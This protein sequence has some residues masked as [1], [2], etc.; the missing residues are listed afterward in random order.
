LG[1]YDIQQVLTIPEPEDL[2][3]NNSPVKRVWEWIHKCLAG[4]EL[5]GQP[6]TLLFKKIFKKF[7]F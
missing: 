2:Q 1:E 3:M 5:K 6:G 4:S 7:P